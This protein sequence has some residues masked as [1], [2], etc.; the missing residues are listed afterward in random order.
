[1]RNNFRKCYVRSRWRHC[2][3]YGS[4]SVICGTFSHTGIGDSASRY[5]S[6]MASNDCT[7]IRIA[8]S[9]DVASLGSMWTKW[10]W[11]MWGKLRSC[12]SMWQ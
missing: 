12:S 5:R 10:D 7:P 6:P 8:K 1:M 2:T 11:G 3:L 4:G 9:H